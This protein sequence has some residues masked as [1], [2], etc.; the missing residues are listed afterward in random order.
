MTMGKQITESKLKNDLPRDLITKASDKTELQQNTHALAIVSRV[1][2]PCPLNMHPDK[3][4]ERFY[5]A[6]NSVIAADFQSN[7][8]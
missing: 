2:M 6:E 4:R 1:L 5:V 7:R 8:C 3:R